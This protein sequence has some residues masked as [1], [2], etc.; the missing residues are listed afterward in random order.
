MFK[1]HLPDLD[2]DHLVGEL[3]LPAHE[4]ARGPAAPVPVLHEA[5]KAGG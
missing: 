1:H 4:V 2:G 3:G 5:V